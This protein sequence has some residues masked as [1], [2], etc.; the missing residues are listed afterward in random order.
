M[1]TTHF[2]KNKF[3]IKEPTLPQLGLLTFTVLL[4]WANYLSKY[5]CDHFR[6]TNEHESVSDKIEIKVEKVQAIK[7]CTDRPNFAKCDL[8]VR[9]KFCNKN[10]YY[11][12]FCC[13]SCTNAGQLT[14]PKK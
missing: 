8:I 7:E 5:F 9:A 4:F 6:A 13:Q 3:Y 12:E 14:P 1:E 10:P 11:A 2:H